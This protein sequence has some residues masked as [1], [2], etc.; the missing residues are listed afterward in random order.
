MKNET[1]RQNIRQEKQ[2]EIKEYFGWLNFFVILV[3]FLALVSFFKTFVFASV[4][5]VGNSMND[6]LKNGDNL[7]VLTNPEIK[8]GDIV[9]FSG[10]DE[11]KFFIKRV[12][13]L[14]GDVIRIVPDGENKGVYRSIN[15]VEEK[16]DEDYAKG[17][18]ETFG[19]SG[20]YVV[21]EGRLF[22]LGDNRE[23]SSDSRGSYVGQPEISKV[24]GVV[25]D[26]V[27]AI[28]DTPLSLLINLL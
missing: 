21:A 17:V 1:F 27:V 19:T 10:E 25:P 8:R 28:K 4:Q 13:G 9:V 7:I 3:A 6:T 11:N 23:H 22:V 14:P 16:L 5:V 15:G 26:W 18:T 2:N 20:K 12:I 24:L